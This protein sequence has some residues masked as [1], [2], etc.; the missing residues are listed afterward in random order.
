MN[1]RNLQQAIAWMIKLQ[2]MESPKDMQ[3]AIISRSFFR[4]IKDG[5]SR[6]V[7]TCMRSKS[8]YKIYRHMYFEPL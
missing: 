4:N 3:F 8:D 7:A 1:N 2:K 5:G 6:I